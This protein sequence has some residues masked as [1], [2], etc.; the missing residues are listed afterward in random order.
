MIQHLRKLGRRQPGVDAPPAP[1]PD[2]F[3]RAQRDDDPL[4]V[5]FLSGHA[6]SGTNWVGGLLNLH[7]AIHIRGEYHFEFLLLG[8]EDFLKHEWYV[9][10]GGP[11]R[12][13][14]ERC[15][16]ETVRRTILATAPEKPG[17]TWIGDQTP[18]RIIPLVPGARHITVVR[19][20]RDVI[21]SW[22]Y[23][24]LRCGPD[25]VPAL[26]EREHRP[27]IRTLLERYQADTEHFERR[28]E[29]LLDNES[30][31]RHLAAGWRTMRS[32]DR[33]TIRR[34]EQGEIDGRAMQIRYE[35]LRS[36][37]ETHR[38]RLYAFL[39]LDSSQAAAPSGEGRT[40]AGFERTDTTSFYRA[41]ESGAW[42]KYMHERCLHWV[43]DTAGEEME[44]AGYA[45]HEPA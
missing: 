5:F 6:R 42:M 29:E 43:W 8:F 31:V 32:R 15:L 37:L 1:E 27:A 28:P 12:E 9:A 10:S 34:M 16:I 41:G 4:R 24:I 7:P 23:H 38:P 13:T 40:A 14:A 18:R 30:W 44:H 25:L 35:D 11:A 45:L 33:E 19:D 17:A 39:D 26:V 3:G 20:P 2:V 22:T 36:D 21:V